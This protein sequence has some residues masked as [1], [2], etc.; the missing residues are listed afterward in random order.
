VQFALRVDAQVPDVLWRL[1]LDL[2]V[3]DGEAVLGRRLVLL[4]PAGAVV[5]LK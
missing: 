4:L 2:R 5:N 1:H 3:L